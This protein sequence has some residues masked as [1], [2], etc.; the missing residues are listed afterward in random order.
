MRSEENGLV[1]LYL[2][3]RFGPFGLGRLGVGTT[4]SGVFLSS[5][6]M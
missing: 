3:L 5:V 1:G 2:R 4:S 6:S